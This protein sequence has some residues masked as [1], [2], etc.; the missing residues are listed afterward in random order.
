[1]LHEMKYAT[2]SVHWDQ[3]DFNLQSSEGEIESVYN[4]TSNGQEKAKQKA[5]LHSKAH[6]ICSMYHL[7][8]QKK[9]CKVRNNVI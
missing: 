4:F 1:M 8:F 3:M 2:H 9:V 5:S 6:H 7:G